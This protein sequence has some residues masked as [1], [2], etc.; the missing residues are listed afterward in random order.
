MVA[1][2]IS[3]VG[4]CVGAITLAP[5]SRASSAL[6][7]TPRAPRNTNFIKYIVSL[8]GLGS[9]E[10][11]GVEAAG[12]ELLEGAPRAAF[13]GPPPPPGLVFSLP[14]RKTRLFSC[15]RRFGGYA[16]PNRQT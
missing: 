14:I 8:R 16:A 4:T 10:G 13:G 15:V 11:A 12:G 1:V 6:L 7:P 3:G 2:V 5:C 9:R